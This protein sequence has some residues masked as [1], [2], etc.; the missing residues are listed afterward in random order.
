M[1]EC[2][3]V[4]ADHAASSEDEFKPNSD[5]N[6]N[7]EEEEDDDDDDEL[8]VVES[9]PGSSPAE[10][11]SETPDKVFSFCMVIV[12][13]ASAAAVVRVLRTNVEVFCVNFFLHV[14]VICYI[15]TSNSRIHLVTEIH[16]IFSS[17]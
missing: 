5:K 13:A 9:T 7:E 1:L 11:E 3:F 17:V 10:S 6:D 15:Y 14:G 4:C 2:N 12:L 16:H 8:S